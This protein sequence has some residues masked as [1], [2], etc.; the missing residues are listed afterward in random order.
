MKNVSIDAPQWR[1]QPPSEPA[2]GAPN[3]ERF[4]YKQELRRAL[5]LFDLLIYGLA[6]IGPFSPVSVF[7][8]V[9]NMSHGMVPLVYLLGLL[10]MIFTALSYMAMTRVF[11]LAGSVY[12]YAARALGPAIG[13]FAGWAILLDY[14]L[15]PTLIY[16][17]C[18]IALHS[19]L[20]GVPS[21]VWVIGMLAVATGVNFAGIEATARANVIMLGLQVLLLL[22][23]LA[24]GAVALAHHVDG[25]HLSFAP[26]YRRSEPILRLGF[27]ALSLA[28]LSFL[29][30]DAISTLSE[31]SR[32]GARAVSRATM[33]S[34]CL[35]AAC[36]VAQTWLASLFV[37]GR[38][39]LPPGD[40]TNAAFYNI[41]GA[42][43]GAWLKFLVAVP[44][45]V[46]AWVGSLAAQAATMRLIFGMA[47]DGKLPR[48][49]A[50][51]HSGR[52]IPDRALLVT[53]AVALVLGVWMVN[54]FELL[55]SLVNFGALFGFLL[56][57]VSVIVH[58]RRERSRNWL[59]HL[60][61]PAIGFC[62]IAYVLWNAEVDAK[63]A[64][65]CWLG[66]GAIVLIALRVR[67]RS[68]GLPDTR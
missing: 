61:A 30:F 13:F 8:I 11:P 42:I 1:A 33:W 58:F 57:N 48:S 62:F 37:L 55:T 28:A 41:A 26:F 35:C 29:G 6:I 44:G 68:I 16:V 52:H 56:L 54:R 38:T 34:L 50:H 22:A 36:F 46:C 40:P 21:V 47:R 32:D 43:G 15:L 2:G 59:R 63:T 17:A 27:G 64:G 45:A 31:E 60:V 23:F 9:F 25:A 19:V 24:T 66:I 51:V 53:A 49:L 14:L 4:G 18:S 20:P 67:N 5:T 39:S 3:L 65:L 12:T 7:G 10:A